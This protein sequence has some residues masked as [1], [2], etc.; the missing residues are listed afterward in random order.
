MVAAGTG[1]LGFGKHRSR[2]VLNYGA[3]LKHAVVSRMT[4]GRAIWG[5]DGTGPGGDYP[6]GD[7]TAHGTGKSV[8]SGHSS[9]PLHDILLGIMNLLLQ[10]TCLR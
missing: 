6:A 5:H 2:R 8:P 1:P 7:T 4:S 10:Y 3:V 9:L